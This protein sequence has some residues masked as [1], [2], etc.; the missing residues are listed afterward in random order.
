MGSIRIPGLPEAGPAAE[1]WPPLPDNDD[2]HT[3]RLDEMFARRL[4][5]GFSSG[6]RA[7]LHAPETG[8]AAQSGEAAL[9]AIAG[10]LPAL[11]D[12]KER[13][14]GQAVGPR[15]RRILEP[16]IE[17]RLDW[18]A[19]TLGRLAARATV[20]VDDASI[21]DRIAGLQQDAS[22]SWHDPAYLRQLG[23]TTVEELRHQGERRGRDPAET[24]ARVR[25]GLSDL[26]A[27]AVEA[28][29]DQ[30]DLAGASGLYDHARPVIAPERQATLDRRFVQAREAALY[31]TS[32][33]TWRASR[34]SRRDR[35][36]PRSSRNVPP[37]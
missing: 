32:T 29:I 1:P 13:T 33:A 31:A 24:D 25:G 11:D 2:E 16:L 26:Y 4:D 15:Q 37:G 17:T 20:E 8:V 36:A 23:R 22:S 35:P 5:T 34:S 28:A 30:D 14:L 10:A 19:G 12:L 18:A 7:L 27:G 3:V 9:E 21:A 6:V